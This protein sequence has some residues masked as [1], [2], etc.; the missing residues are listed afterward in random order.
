MVALINFLR[1]PHRVLGFFFVFLVILA[2]ATSGCQTTRGRAI[3]PENMVPTVLSLA[4]GDVLDISFASATNM[5]AIRRVG[6][7]G[8]ITMPTIGQVQVAGK[9]VAQVEAELKER[10]AKELQDPELFVNLAQSGNVVYVSGSVARP[11]RIV[12]ERPL[13]ALEAILEAGGFTPDANLKKVTVIR[14]EG[15]SNTTYDL[16][17]QPVYS[18]GPVSPFYL[19][20]RDVVNVPKKVQWF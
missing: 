17:L 8:S 16:D 4:P 12:L 13:T 7:E 9:T 20:P 19:M 15:Q 5:N 11:G 2:V 6:P 1:Q 3:G 10:Y 18:G 14:Y